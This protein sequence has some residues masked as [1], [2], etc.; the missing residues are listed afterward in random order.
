MSFDKGSLSTTCLQTGLMTLIS[1]PLEAVDFRR[2][3]C[4][5]SRPSD[6]REVPWNEKIDSPAWRKLERRQAANTFQLSA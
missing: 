3:P 1:S 6:K 5:S 2:G 4:L